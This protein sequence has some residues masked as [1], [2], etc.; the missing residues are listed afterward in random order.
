MQKM[1]NAAKAIKKVKYQVWVSSQTN[2]KPYDFKLPFVIT[3]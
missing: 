3:L 1:E 2:R